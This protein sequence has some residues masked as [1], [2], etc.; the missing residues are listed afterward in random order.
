MT[1]PSLKIAIVSDLH[2]GDQAREFDMQPNGKAPYPDYPGY[3]EFFRRA[4]EKYTLSADMLVISGDVTHKAQ[5]SQFAHAGGVIRKLAEMLKVPDGQI[6][7]V[8]GNHD[9]NW[10]VATLATQSGEPFWFDYRFAPFKHGSSQAGCPDAMVSALLEPPHF[11]LHEH[12]AADVWCFNSAAYDLP[13]Q[14]PHRGEIRERH[15]AEL[16]S[17]LEARYNGVAKDRYRIFVT[18]HHPKP[19]PEL[20]PDIPDFS[21]MVNGESLLDLLMDHRFDLILHGHKHRPWCRPFLESGKDPIVVWCSGSFAQTLGAA[22]Y[23]SIGNLWHL[24]EMQGANSAGHCYGV[25]K[26]WAFAPS[27]GWVPSRP[28]HHGI[29]NVTPFGY[30]ADRATITDL[31]RTELAAS[32]AAKPVIRW[33][34]MRAKHPVLQYQPGPIVW[35]VLDELASELKFRNHGERDSLDQ[36][37]IVKEDGS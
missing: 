21:G 5:P 35:K 7:A 30:L 34:D 37:M 2:V 26:S 11:F 24:A 12:A 23:G 13:D 6:I 9:L 19:Q 4:I 31:S 18:H 27:Q 8:P 10:D 16:Q 1:A 15:R 17:K 22:Y 29:D 28:A 25:V 20:Y 36:L 33:E 3:L 14:K 32:L